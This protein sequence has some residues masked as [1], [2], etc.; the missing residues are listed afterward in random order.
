VGED[1]A[2]LFL[3][4]CCRL[5]EEYVI[6]H[7]QG[8]EARF[9][10]LVVRSGND[11]HVGKFRYFKYFLVMTESMLFGNSMLLGHSGFSSLEDIGNT[12][13]AG[14]RDLTFTI[15]GYRRIITIKD[16]QALTKSVAGSRIQFANQDDD[17]EIGANIPGTIVKILVEEGDIV[18]QGQPIAIIEAMKMETNVI[19]TG[20]GQIARIYIKEG[21]SVKSG[22]LIARL[23]DVQ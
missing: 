3:S 8:L 20:D 6:A 11:Y 19:A 1:L 21:E 15:N 18:K 22:Q 12:D 2:T 13:E 10:M 17:K 14:N 7:F 5:L 4:L 16:K 9:D 23:E